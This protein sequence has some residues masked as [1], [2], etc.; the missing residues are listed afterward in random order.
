ME[1]K[2]IKQSTLISAF[3]L[4]SIL[5]TGC[6]Y[7]TLAAKD[8]LSRGQQIRI[9]KSNSI[10]LEFS[11]PTGKVDKT[12]NKFKNLLRD[13]LIH[14]GYIVFSSANSA[15]LILKI[16]THYYLKNVG[17]KTFF[18]FFKL[19]WPFSYSERK[20]SGMKVSISCITHR[21]R[22][23]WNKRYI[24]YRKGS[25]GGFKGQVRWSEGDHYE[26]IVD[27]IIEGLLTDTEE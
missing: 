9:K 23:K 24:A 19:G 3:L 15:D 7:Y 6:V 27:A 8:Q 22:G 16:R 1:I 12:F 21:G 14:N 10:Y 13:Q 20:I 18:L 26:K 11:E 25:Y 5:L 4:L 17:H 2:N